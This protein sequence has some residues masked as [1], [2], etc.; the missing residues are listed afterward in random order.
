MRLGFV[1]T[2]TITAALIE[3]LNATGA[4]YAI[5]VSPRNADTAAA[6]A[7][8]Y[9]N[10]RVAASNQAVLDTSDLV[11]LAVRPQIAEA[12]LPEL[13]FRPDHHVVSLIAA[14]SHAYLTRVTA[15]AGTV[16]RA[17]PIPSVARRQGPTAFFPPHPTVKA[18]FASLGTAIELGDET[19]FHAFA[20]GT[21][22]MASYFQFAHTIERWMAGNGVAQAEAHA[23][24]GQMLLGLAGHWAE[25][26]ERD[27]AQLADE[28]QT[29]GGINEQIRTHLT[30][31]GAF[32]EVAAALDAV[33]ARLL[34]ARA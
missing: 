13:R 10:V 4:E 11:M 6:L 2:G 25:T 18:L 19:A 24:V 27:F 30:D 12:V 7:A 16:T 32:A 29:L 17:V 8:R 26:P 5:T 14:V 28:H 23:F 21:A 1:G 33:K 22:M 15:P 3:G 9:A 34:K 20:A 31:V